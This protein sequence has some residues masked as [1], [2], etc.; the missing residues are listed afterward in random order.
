MAD[1]EITPEEDALDKKFM[2]IINRED[3]FKAKANPKKS[4]KVEVKKAEAKAS[5]NSS[6][7]DVSDLDETKEEESLDRSFNNLIDK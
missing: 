6:I 7:L 2:N 3:R 1:L 5:K 4:A